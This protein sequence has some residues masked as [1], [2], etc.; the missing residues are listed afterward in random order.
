MRK[1]LILLALPLLLVACKKD[2]EN[3]NPGSSNSGNSG[4]TGGS[5]TES[6]LSFSMSG[7]ALGGDYLCSTDSPDGASYA[8]LPAVVD[9]PTGQAMSWAASG[10]TNDGEHYIQGYFFTPAVG[11]GTYILEQDG[12]TGMALVIWE[13]NNG[14][15]G[16]FLGNFEIVSGTAVMSNY[17]ST[18]LGSDNS[19]RVE[20]NGDFENDDTGEVVTVTNGVLQIH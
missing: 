20:F 7:G 17:S 8:F 11:N 19:G 6:I 16:D 4:N 9:Q 10:P 13:N 2:E 3:N 18:N 15:F 12:D 1:F 14:T 5:I